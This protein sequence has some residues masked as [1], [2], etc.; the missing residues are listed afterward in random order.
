MSLSFSFS[1]TAEK[2]SKIWH[3]MNNNVTNEILCKSN[4]LLM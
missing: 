2:V 1:I 3:Y 4:V